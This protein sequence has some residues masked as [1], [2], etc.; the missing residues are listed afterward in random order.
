MTQIKIGLLGFG[1]IMANAHLPVLL[2]HPAFKIEWA[3]D[4]SESRLKLA[5]DSWGIKPVKTNE[6]E[7]NLSDIDL[8]IVTLPLKVRMHYLPLISKADKKVF[9]EK[10][11]ALN[12]N[13][14]RE[15]EQLFP[16][17]S[18]VFIGFQRRYYQ[19]TTALRSLVDSGIFGPIRKVEFSHAFLNVKSVQGN[20]ISNEALAVGGTML[21]SAIHGIDQLVFA[22]G[23]NSFSETNSQKVLN[24]KLDFH[25]TGTTRLHS[26]AGEVEL[27]YCISRLITN[28][29]F[30]RLYFENAEVFVEDKCSASYFV[31]SKEMKWPIEFS[32]EFDDSVGALNMDQAFVMLWD[33]I[34]GCIN[35]GQECHVE[36]TKCVPVIGFVEQFYSSNQ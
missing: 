1:E 34:A 22:L 13:E 31:K 10:P 18:Q 19:N 27:E 8:V 3:C 7:G 32:N 14:V 6:F 2:N 12:Q 35:I 25:A 26:N 21:E 5:E 15:I 11:F 24:R 33:A 23:I 20:F 36:L 28:G 16:K 4:A 17:P 29:N 30:F 9:L